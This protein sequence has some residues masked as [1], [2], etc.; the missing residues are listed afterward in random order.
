MNNKVRRKKVLSSRAIATRVLSDVLGGKSL[1][2]S[3]NNNHT[4]VADDEYSL[5]KEICFGCVRWYLQIEQIMKFLMRKSLAKKQPQIHALIA[6]GIYQL[7]RMRIKE[8][9]AINETVKVCDELKRSWA[10]GLVNGIL[11]EYQ[12]SKFKAFK[13]ENEDMVF[14]S[15][16]PAWLIDMFEKSWGTSKTME[17]IENNN[18]PGPLTLRV[19]TKF[20]TREAYLDMLAKENIEA[21]C[22][23]FSDKG[24]QL[25]NPLPVERI[26]EFNEGAVSVQDEAAQLAPSIL[27]YCEEHLIL[28]ACCAPGGKTCDILESKHEVG[29]LLSVDSN[30]TRLK[31]AEENAA[32]LGL[33]GN[34]LNADLCKIDDWWDGNQFDRIML[35]APC[36]GT[37][38]IRRNPDIK[39]LRKASD[40]SK[41]AEKQFDIM[42]AIW[43]TLKPDGVLLYITCSVLPEENDLV[44]EKFIKFQKDVK[45]SQIEINCGISTKYGKQLF[46]EKNAHDGFYYATLIKV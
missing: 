15:S 25:K 31:K 16:H 13:S 38:V 6:I 10:K 32:R 19:N 43:P 9:A 22:T 14:T 36:S 39:I 37:G 5:F 12:R 18:N 33:H 30:G 29:S 45:V 40:I 23:T 20:T 34:F 35:D 44:I 3:L 7:S 4:L 26:P 42:S 24:I 28:D 8:H 17:L 2:D 41:L 21:S 46:P 1:T 27:D 11:R